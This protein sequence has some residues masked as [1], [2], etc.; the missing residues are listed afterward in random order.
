M[1]KILQ[2]L[3]IIIIISVGQTATAKLWSIGLGLEGGLPNGDISN[4]YNFIAGLTARVQVHAGPGYVTFTTG[5]LAFTPKSISGVDTKAALQVPVKFGYK[6]VFLDHFFAMLELGYSNFTFYSVDSNNS[7]V[8][9][10]T[11]GFTYAPGIGV[12][13][14]KL[15][16]SIRYE[17]FAVSVAGT[18]TNVSFIALRLGFNF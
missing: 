10:K 5:G 14:A 16:A 9:Q 11:G 15:E 12:Q 18:N 4:S 2:G 6:Y 3:L 7:L 8:S 13:A 1:K 17:S